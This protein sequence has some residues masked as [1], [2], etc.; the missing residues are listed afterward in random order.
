[1]EAICSSET[2]DC[3]RTILYNNREDRT[4]QGGSNFQIPMQPNFQAFNH[5]QSRAIWIENRIWN[6]KFQ[7]E[8]IAYF[9]FTTNWV[10]DMTSDVKCYYLR[11]N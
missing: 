5:M 11:V 3:L 10:C 6:K 8:V 9:I 4:M 1:M 2:S 7:E